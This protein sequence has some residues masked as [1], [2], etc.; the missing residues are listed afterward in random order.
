MTGLHLRAVVEKRCL[1][2]EFEVSAGEVLAILGANGAGKSSALQVI[3]GLLRPDSGMVTAGRHLLTDVA[4]GVHVPVHR[5]NVGLLQ[6]DSM[7]FPH[8]D[9][10][11]NVAFGPRSSSGRRGAS[12]A[13]DRWLTKVGARDL[14]SRMPRELSGG[15]A[16]RVALA[17]ALAAEPDVLLLDEPMAGLDVE[18][19]TSMRAL[20]RDVLTDGGRCAVLVTHELLDVTSLADRVVIID[21]GRVV[22]SG[23]VASVLSAPGT[24][25]GAR[26]AGVN[27]VGGFAQENGTLC[28][29][30]GLRLVGTGGPTVPGTPAIAVFAP[31]AVR[32]TRLR[33]A[34]D[35]FGNVIEVDVTELDH[36]GAAIRVRAEPVEGGTDAVFAD[37]SA[38]VAAELRLVPGERVYFSVPAAAVAI[39][40]GG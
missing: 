7:L 25:F 4:A 21:R 40:P 5:R 37:I 14:A 38:H 9:V 17:R 28:A 34:D 22:E 27:L 36:R 10:M 20:L 8:L 26:F 19:A 23:P 32:I 39:R 3:A 1:E 13:A 24:D 33:P 31:A 6:Q 29:E 35:A 12:A 2:V 11:A 16:Q 15:Q 30:A 18:A